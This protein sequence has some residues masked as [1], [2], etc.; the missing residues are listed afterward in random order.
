MNT[1]SGMVSSAFRV[2]HD[3]DADAITLQRRD[4]VVAGTI[5]R[6]EMVALDVDAEGQAPGIEF[7]IA[8][9]MLTFLDR[10][11]GEFVVPDRLDVTADTA[12]SG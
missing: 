4:G 5:R 12:S 8:S 11:G 9:V 7:A 10:C 6:E 2:R 3:A 1:T